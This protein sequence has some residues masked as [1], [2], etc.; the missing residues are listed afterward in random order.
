MVT[1]EKNKVNVADVIPPPPPGRGAEL[2]SPGPGPRA[3]AG[4]GLRYDLIELF[5]FAY[6]DFVARPDEVLQAIGFGRAHHRVL[7]FVNRTPGLTVAELLGI[8]RITKQSLGRVLK[9]LIDAG[10]VEQKEGRRDRRQRHLCPT[11]AGRALAER[12]SRLQSEQIVAAL[13]QAG[14]GGDEAVKRFLLAMISA[15]DRADVARRI[16]GDPPEG[17]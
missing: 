11:A 7:Y 14:E 4:P 15:Q 12:L 10:Y 3:A 16:G 1:V 9:E 13:G 6:R 8:L 2:S 5:F 17:T